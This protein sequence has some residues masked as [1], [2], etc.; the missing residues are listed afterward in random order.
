[1]RKAVGPPPGARDPASLDLALIG[2]CSFGALV[3]RRARVVW[4]CMPRFDG[5]PVFHALLDSAEGIGQEGTFA[6]EIEDFARSEQAYDPGTAI[7]RTRL[8]DGAGNGVDGGRLRAALL[9]PRPHLPARAARAARAAPQ[10][11]GAGALRRSPAQRLGFPDARRP[12]AAATTCVSRPPAE[13][14]GSRPTRRSPM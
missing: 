13:R 10:R 2:N 4:C 9:H 7:L 11:P 3:D 14:C 6:V 12:R 5:D 1:M 8:Y